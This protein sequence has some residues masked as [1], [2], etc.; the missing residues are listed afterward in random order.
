MYIIPH[1]CVRIH[2]GAERTHAHD[3]AGRIV[4][5]RNRMHVY[6]GAMHP[7]ARSQLMH[8]KRIHLSIDIG[9]VY[10]YKLIQT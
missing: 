6:M 3:V 2:T 1:L 7:L 5:T 4:G 10:R 8:H 9:P